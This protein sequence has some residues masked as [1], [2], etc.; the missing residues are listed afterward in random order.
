MKSNGKIVKF[1]AST[2]YHILL[3]FIYAIAASQAVWSFSYKWTTIVDHPQ[4][5]IG[6]TLAGDIPKPYAFRLLMPTVVQQ[7]ETL[8]PESTGTVLQERSEQ[9]LLR[10]VPDNSHLDPQSA[11]SYGLI[12]MMN[13]AMLIATMFL[14]R[15]ATALFLPGV[16]RT[17]VIRD[18]SPLLFV[19]LLSISYRVDNG[20]IYDFSE[21]LLLTSYLVAVICSRN[22]IALALIALAC[23]NKETAVLFPVFGI[24]IRWQRGDWQNSAKIAVAGE[25]VAA[26]A[27]YGI[28]HIWCMG[29]AG[30]S[31]EWHFFGNLKFW[32]SAYPY[33]AV[34][35]PHIPLIPL[36]KPSNVLVAAPLIACVLAYWSEKPRVL[37]LLIGASA[38][39]NLPL[40]LFFSYRDEFRNLSLM[41]PMLFLA[42]V[43]TLSK[44]YQTRPVDPV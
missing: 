27:V 16:Q 13:F 8:L 38:I 23:V 12:V 21:L 11:R 5:S 7:L 1:G 4:Y 6:R 10:T 39:L 28:V 36:P 25:F 40:F 24:L 2:A 34:T 30:G 41:Y 26:F 20:F 19:L 37:R 29:R 14:L 43:H 42:A 3:L 22:L 44:F 33:I 32:A 18:V 35:T 9:T 31:V 17:G 15:S